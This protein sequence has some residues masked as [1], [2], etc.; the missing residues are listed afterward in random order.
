MTKWEPIGTAPK[1]GTV[2]MVL[3]GSM[4]TVAYWDTDDKDEDGQVWRLYGT[5]ECL[6]P[7]AWMPLPEPPK[8]IIND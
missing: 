3:A 2:I 6:N 1:D 7:I 4:M 8:E 5:S